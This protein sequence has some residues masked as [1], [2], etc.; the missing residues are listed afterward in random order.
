MAGTE[1]YYTWR[2][3]LYWHDNYT[4]GSY[5][6]TYKS[7]KNFSGSSSYVVGIDLVFSA[8]TRTG[9]NFLG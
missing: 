4:G 2:V 9:Y 8:P 1:L 7:G 3:D 6:H 5:T